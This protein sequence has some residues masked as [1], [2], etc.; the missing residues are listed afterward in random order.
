[1]AAT[2]KRAARGRGG[3][4]R[5]ALDAGDGGARPRPRSPRTSRRSP[6][7]AP[8]RTT[9]RWWR[10][11]CCA[12]ST[13]RSTGEPVRLAAGGRGLMEQKLSFETDDPRRRAR[14]AAPRQRPQ[15]RDR[16]RRIHR[17]H[18]RA[19]RH[20]ARLPRPRRQGARRDRVDGPRRGARGARRRRRADRRRHP[21][22]ERHQ[23][24][25]Q[26]RRPGLR[27]EGRVP[28]PADL[29]GDRRDPRR[30]AAGGD[31]GQGR[32]PRRCR[33]SP[34]SPRRWRRT[35]PSSPSR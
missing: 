15:A 6:T 29:R 18:R 35:I 5:P 16:P 26:A 20:A 24:G 25:R 30:R 10:G 22:H 32:V 4:G 19:G 11:T 21:R 3:A 8:R 17:R 34:T 13:W 2:P 14:R 28:R 23:P 7:G 9:G 27:R 12:A 31:A 1:M 33:T